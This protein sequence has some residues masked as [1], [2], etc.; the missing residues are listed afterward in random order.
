MNRIKWISENIDSN[1]IDSIQNM[2]DKFDL[3]DNFKEKE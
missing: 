2:E 1:Q 3:K